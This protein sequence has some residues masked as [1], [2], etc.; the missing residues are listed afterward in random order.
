MGA[1][2]L[3]AS[4]IS[5]F[6]NGSVTVTPAQSTGAVYGRIR[7]WWEWTPKHQNIFDYNGHGANVTFMVAVRALPSLKNQKAVRINKAFAETML[8]IQASVMPA[9]TPDSIVRKTESHLYGGNI[10]WTNFM[11]LGVKYGNRINYFIPESNTNGEKED[12]GLLPVFSVGSV[13][14]II[15]EAW[16]PGAKDNDCYVI[17]A[18]DAERPDV[19]HNATYKGF[20]HMFWKAST[21]ARVAGLPNGQRLGPF[22]Q[23]GLPVIRDP[24]AEYTKVLVPIIAN[25]STNGRLEDGYSRLFVPKYLVDLQ[26]AGTLAKDVY[27]YGTP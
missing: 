11:G 22:P 8:R 1:L 10:A 25:G 27:P 17:R 7:D 24:K 23:A 4:S 19:F 26:P 3:M 18:F 2:Q 16:I 14:E 12:A 15:G 21:I 20:E 13:V 6:S 5:V 9:G